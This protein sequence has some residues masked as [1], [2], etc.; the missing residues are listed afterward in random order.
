MGRQLCLCAAPTRKSLKTLKKTHAG[1]NI[2]GKT[3]LKVA[4]DQ[5]YQGVVQVRL[6]TYLPAC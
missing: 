4:S 2:G 5:G 6:A 3:V 1:V